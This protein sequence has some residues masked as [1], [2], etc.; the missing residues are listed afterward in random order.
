ME[1]VRILNI[2]AVWV[3]ESWDWILLESKWLGGWL[4]AIQF[5]RLRHQI[6][7]TSFDLVSQNRGFFWLWSP[8]PSEPVQKRAS[9]SAWFCSG[10]TKLSKNL[11]VHKEF[12]GNLVLTKENEHYHRAKNPRGC[13]RCIANSKIMTTSSH[14]RAALPHCAETRMSSGSYAQPRLMTR[15]SDRNITPL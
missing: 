8:G 1:N 5:I 14:T 6:T 4:A 15:S 7:A 9:Q 11:V 10:K 3:W 2:R 12:V 13:K